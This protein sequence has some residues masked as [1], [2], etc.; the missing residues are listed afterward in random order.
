MRWTCAAWPDPPCARVAAGRELDLSRSVATFVARRPVAMSSSYPS[1]RFR[2]V[3]SL[4]N[5]RSV[6]LRRR[7][8]GSR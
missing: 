5:E 1:S 2:G 4:A 6:L 7:D 3:R 8:G